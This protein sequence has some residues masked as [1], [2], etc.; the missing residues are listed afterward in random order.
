MNEYKCPVCV[1]WETS[2]GSPNLIQHIKNIAKTE[3]LTNHL[4]KKTD[5]S[6][7]ADWLRDNLKL[8][9]ITSYV[10]K[11]GKDNFRLSI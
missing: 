10:I 9:E 11:V 7:H 5:K 1:G 3:L 4:L 8:E 2:S 6:P